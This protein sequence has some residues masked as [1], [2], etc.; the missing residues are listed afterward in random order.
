MPH[1]SGCS[2]ENFAR[3][4]YRCD[5]T[6]DVMV[7][8]SCPHQHCCYLFITFDFLACLQLIE[9]GGADEDRTRDLLTASQIILPLS[10]T[11][12]NSLE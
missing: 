12:R 1:F 3:M 7:R 10:S 9:N 2:F 5:Q 11:Y 4:R 6:A 8:K